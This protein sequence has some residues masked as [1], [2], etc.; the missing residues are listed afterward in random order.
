MGFLNTRH[1]TTEFSK[2]EEVVADM[3]KVKRMVTEGKGK[4][5][6]LVEAVK[7]IWII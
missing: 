3:V 1:D 2:D 7:P 5:A 6:K 4:N